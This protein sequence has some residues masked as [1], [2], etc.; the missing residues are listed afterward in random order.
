[1]GANHRAPAV[2]VARFLAVFG[3]P[4]WTTIITIAVVAVLVLLRHPRTAVALA[5]TV[6]LSSIAFS[7]IKVVLERP[8][9][10]SAMMQLTTFSYPSGH[11]TTAAALALTIA[12]T[13]PRVW[14]RVWVWIA[15]SGWIAF[16]AWSR[17][18]L[19]L[20]WLSDVLAGALLGASVAV[21]V[22]GVL[23]QLSRRV[24]WLRPATLPA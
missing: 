5:S 15:G 14:V 7:T 19:E 16:I 17:T 9:P 3:G 4:L 23:R 1:M 8:R 2:A 10:S 24:R 20:H 18:Y 6:S 13:L 22:D 12:I 21:L 11:T